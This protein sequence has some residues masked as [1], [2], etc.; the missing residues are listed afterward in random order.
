MMFKSLI[1][2][3]V[4]LCGFI[5][6]SI[7]LLNVFNL[8]R[9][10]WPPLKKSD[11]RGGVLLAGV[12][13]GVYRSPVKKFSRS[14]SLQ[15]NT[16]LCVSFP[17]IPIDYSEYLLKSR[18]YMYSLFQKIDQSV[19]HEETDDDPFFVDFPDHDTACFVALFNQVHFNKGV[20]RAN[21]YA[22]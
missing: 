2:V 1:F 12:S 15:V 7:V 3:V 19:V 21:I 5:I 9:N 13:K 14:T 4:F 18:F 10:I 20:S 11:H 17:T 6:M 16:H 8:L 22:S